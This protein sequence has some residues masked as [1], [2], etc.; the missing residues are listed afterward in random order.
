LTT[1]STTIRPFQGWPPAGYERIGHGNY[2]VR[3]WAY[4]KGWSKPLRS[5]L[6]RKNMLISK[7]AIQSIVYFDN[8]NKTVK[9][10]PE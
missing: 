5:I 3:M 10:Y 8:I 1:S 4:G 2:D 9:R 6:I 7:F